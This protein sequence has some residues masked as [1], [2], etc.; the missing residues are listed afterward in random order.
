MARVGI[1]NWGD[2]PLP[3]FANAAIAGRKVAEIEVGVSPATSLRR[4]SSRIDPLDEPVKNSRPDLVL[5]DQVLD[6]VFQVWIIVDLDD[7][8]FA[9]GFL[10]VDA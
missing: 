10:D 3:A 8:D 7:D 5:A 6:P 2:G 4:A 1:A 9:V